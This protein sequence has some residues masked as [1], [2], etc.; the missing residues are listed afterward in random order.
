MIYRKTDLLLSHKFR[1]CDICG[2]SEE[3]REA[4]AERHTQR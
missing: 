1:I 2:V 4:V 3:W